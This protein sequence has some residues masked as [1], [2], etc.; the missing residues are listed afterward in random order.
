MSRVD[1][2]R[3]AKSYQAYNQSGL[4]FLMVQLTFSKLFVCP[5]G[6]SIDLVASQ[7]DKHY[8]LLP[9]VCGAS[10]VQGRHQAPHARV[11]LS[12]SNVV[13]SVTGYYAG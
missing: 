10:L 3:I 11:G 6:G 2:S 1:A 9:K 8:S 12:T 4:R 13:Q 5:D 7:Y